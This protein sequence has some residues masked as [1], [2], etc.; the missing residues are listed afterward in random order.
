MVKVDWHDAEKRVQE[1]VCI[2]GTEFERTV[3]EFI[4]PDF[5]KTS[6]KP[7]VSVIKN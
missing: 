4:D 2:T 6:P 3:L 1:M 7:S 5:A